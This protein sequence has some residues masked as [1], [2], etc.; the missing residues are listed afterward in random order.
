[1]NLTLQV[2]SYYRV[3][4]I[5]D[6]NDFEKNFENSRNSFIY[7]NLRKDIQWILLDL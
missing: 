7:N 4:S 3:K 1:M 6:A 5:E 2:L